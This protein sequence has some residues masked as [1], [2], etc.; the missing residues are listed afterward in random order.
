MASSSG[1]WI[2]SFNGEIYNFKELRKALEAEGRQLRSRCDTE[3]LVEAID[4]WGMRTAL[5]RSNAMFAL[6][7]WDRQRRQLH[8]ARDRMGEKPLF[9]GWAARQFVFG[10]ELKALAAHPQFSR[11]VDR[12]ALALYMRHNCVP[13][14]YAIYEGV[15]KLRPG[16]CLV[17]ERTDRT[18]RCSPQA[19]WWSPEEALPDHPNGAMTR[20]GEARRWLE[21][22]LVDSVRLRTVADVP[23]GAF[24][25]GGI[26]SSLVAALMTQCSERVRTYTI[27]FEDPGFDE[28]A[29][30]R[31]VARRLGTDHT[32]AILG[33]EE[34]QAA[35]PGL[36]DLYDEPFADSSQ[37]P[38]LLVSRLARQQ[39]TVVLSGDG[40]DELFGGYNRHLWWQRFGRQLERVP[41]PLRRAAAGAL[42][43][44]SPDAVESAFGRLARLVPAAR[45]RNPSLKVRKVADIIA[46]P[47]AE[48]AYLR[49]VSHWPD[50]LAVVPGAREVPTL[51]SD[52]SRWPLSDRVERILYLD[53]VTYLP[54]DILTKVDRATMAVGLEGRLPLLDHRVVEAA[55]QLPMSMKVGGGETKRVLREILYSR[56]P[57]ELVN[58]SKMGFGVPLRKWLAGGLRD[59]AEQLLNRKSLDS[60]GFLSADPV[61]KMWESHLAGEVDASHPLWDVLMFQAWAQRWSPT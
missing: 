14:P 52:G 56:I 8:L 48:D 24:L 11:R 37:L 29:D 5:R 61:R 19:A 42:A 55:W 60:G 45:V 57:K 18:L 32:E 46:L 36:P 34:A 47:S 40:G 28:S 30:A 4:A 17:V 26:D 33:T 7:A 49:L 22:L 41:L 21:D 58:R 53:M 16:H 15:N 10:S 54:D 35:I 51:V 13:A 25:S 20:P 31:R 50:P 39:V 43:A 38:T 1:R 27:G 6:A 9:Y 23:V 2:I 59:W 3:V 12:D 44:P